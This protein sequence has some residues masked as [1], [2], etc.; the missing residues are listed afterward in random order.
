MIAISSVEFGEDVEREVLDTLRSGI[1]AQGPKVQKLEEAF[2]ELIGARHAVAVNNGTTALVA[3]LQVQD[4]EP[5]DEVLTSPF[6]F[7]ATVNAILEAGATVRF[8]DISAADFTL[9][10][11][12]VEERISDRT[13]VLLPVHLYGQSADMSSL[14]TIA[15]RRGLG[16]VEDAAQAHG[17]TFDG[18]GVGTFGLG[19]FSFYAT[20]NLT[21]GEGGMVTTNDDAVADRLRVLRN[22]G[23]RARYQY[24]MVG[25]NYRM[26]DLQASLALPQIPRYSRQVDQRRRNA[27]MLTTGLKDVVGLTLPAQL[28]GREHVWHQYTL[29]VDEA[30]SID[31]SEL[32]SRLQES[33][34]GSGIYYPRTAYDYD[35]YREHPRVMI[36]PTPVATSV[37]E[38][39]LSIPVHAALS[40]DDVDVV[41]GAVRSAMGQ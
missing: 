22:Q 40:V 38:R 7:V 5:G 13:K 18:Q 20:K 17:A 4:L 34:V 35:C 3:A 29:L 14:T 41:V 37:A 11:A 10:G 12:V 6:T 32:S 30:A 16:I 1:V 15:Q 25:H 36:E 31:R 23:M 33:G 19:C 8:A 27:E 24:E 28:P 9:D 26:T 2:A 21:T 39:C